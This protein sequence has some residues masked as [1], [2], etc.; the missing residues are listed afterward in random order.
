MRR[1]DGDGDGDGDG[2]CLLLLERSVLEGG[3]GGSLGDWED[4][5]GLE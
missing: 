1:L 5:Y 4:W 2:R 3:G